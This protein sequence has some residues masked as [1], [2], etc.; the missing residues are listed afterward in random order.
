MEQEMNK[1]EEYEQ[2]LAKEEANE[3][4][5][6]KQEVNERKQY[7]AEMTTKQKLA[8]IFQYY[9]W[10]MIGIV[11]AVVVLIVIG[12]TVYHA[13][14]P[15]VLNLA[16]INNNGEVA[17]QDYVRESYREYYGLNDKNHINIYCN[18]NKSSNGE[19]MYEEGA[20][21]DDESSLYM[22]SPADEAMGYA[23]TVTVLDA[24]ICDEKA[25]ELY[26]SAEETAAIENVI[27]EE[28]YKKIEDKV[29]IKS[30][31]NKVKLGGEPYG[32]AIDVSDTE[33]IKNC[34]LTYEK[35]YLVIPSTRKMNE[36]NVVNFINF[37]FELSESE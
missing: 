7:F 6:H 18:F 12:K 14:Q 29:V 34:N 36:E 15:T 11:V 3:Q 5:E 20:S 13:S 10:H 23:M 17:M 22:Q 31:P 9:T 21:L 28:L 25:L 32:V 30:D 24:M 27:P 35:A 8:Y 16:F 1:K 19:T 26:A 2:E 4:E 33:F 37:M